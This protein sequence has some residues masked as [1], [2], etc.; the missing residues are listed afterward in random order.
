[1]EL[2]LKLNELNFKKSFLDFLQLKIFIQ[3][4]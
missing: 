3:K 1:M 4:Y 2:F